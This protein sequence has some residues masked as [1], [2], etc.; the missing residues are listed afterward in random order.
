MLTLE[1]FEG[2]QLPEL[3][4]WFPD[5]QSCQT[6]GG[7][8]FRFPFTEAT[9]RADARLGELPC[10]ALVDDDGRLA[11]FGQYYLR[12]GRC[13]LGRLAIAP[14]RRGRGLGTTLVHELGRRGQ[15]ALGVSGLSLFVLPGNERALRLYRRLGFCEATYPEPLPGME[16]C[17][18][19]ISPG[20]L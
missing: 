12:L 6:W 17:V 20:S 4:R 3:M 14:G 2:G 1:P 9:F 8:D 7:P 5:R 15:A 13:H 19:M 16:G 10:F 11:G 18:Y